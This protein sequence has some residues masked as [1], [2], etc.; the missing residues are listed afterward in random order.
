MY[1]NPIYTVKNYYYKCVKY[2]LEN[3]IIFCYIIIVLLTI[4]FC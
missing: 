1:K 2:N 4:L 3:I